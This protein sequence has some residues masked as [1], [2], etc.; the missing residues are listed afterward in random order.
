MVNYK[1]YFVPRPSPRPNSTLERIKAC[2]EWAKNG[3]INVEKDHKST[4]IVNI[5]FPPYFLAPLPPITCNT[6]RQLN[7]RLVSRHLP[8]ST[9]KSYSVK[10]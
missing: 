6:I 2:M 4:A 10:T 1:D 9:V 7:Y 8:V 5:A 3:T